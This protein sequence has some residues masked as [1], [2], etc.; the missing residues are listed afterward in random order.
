MGTIL[1]ISIPVLLLAI[2]AIA[3]T[4]TIWHFYRKAKDTMRSLFGTDNIRELAESRAEQEANTPKSVSGMDAIYAPTIQSDFPELNIVEM[5]GIAEKHLTQY[6][7]NK[8][9]TAIHIHKTSI[10]KYIK[11][12]GTCVIVFQ[13]GVQYHTGTTK[14]QSR[15]NTHMMYIQDAVEYGQ[16]TGHSVNCPHC[17]G[18]LTSLGA[19][20]CEYCG[21]EVIPINI[22]VWDLHKIEEA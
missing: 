15:Y 7:T 22:H 5:K 8:K 9:F 1:G 12:S 20:F 21:S 18:A 14:V 19:K 4:A 17:G 2:G 6:L 11:K 3:L 10:L 13:S 16:S